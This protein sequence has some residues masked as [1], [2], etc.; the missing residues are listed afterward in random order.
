[1][2]WR[3]MVIRGAIRRHLNQH[4]SLRSTQC[5][6][7][8]RRPPVASRSPACDYSE[9][10]SVPNSYL[11]SPPPP[12][13]DLWFKSRDLFQLTVN[14]TCWMLNP[15]LNLKDTRGNYRRWRKKY[16]FVV[17]T[18]FSNSSSSRCFLGVDCLI[19]T[20]CVLQITGNVSG[21]ISW[22]WPTSKW[23]SSTLRKVSYLRDPCFNLGSHRED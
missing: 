13:I 11:P 20:G 8:G 7:H 1:M 9:T 10:N 6:A 3:E 14:Q 22:S 21:W 16:R 17:H 5:D 12:L 19:S 18:F 23:P 2:K 15:L 4:P